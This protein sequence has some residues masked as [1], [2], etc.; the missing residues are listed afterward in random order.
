MGSKFIIYLKLILIISSLFA[1]LGGL[2]PF[3]L[4]VLLMPKVKKFD[5]KRIKL[6]NEFQEFYSMRLNLDVLNLISVG[7]STIRAFRNGEVYREKRQV[8]IF[9]N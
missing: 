7:P 2:N 8:T 9:V 6:Q 5:P 4:R 3:F 1:G